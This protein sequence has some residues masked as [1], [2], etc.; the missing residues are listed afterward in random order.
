MADEDPE[1]AAWFLVNR[2]L[3]GKGTTDCDAHQWYKADGVVEHCYHCTRGTAALRSG[4]LQ[5]R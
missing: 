4:A 5:R 2:G 1:A 3:A